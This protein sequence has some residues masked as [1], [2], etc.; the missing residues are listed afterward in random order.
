MVNLSY[1]LRR[2]NI[3]TNITKKQ[4]ESLEAMCL[5]F[6]NSMRE[7]LIDPQ[8]VNDFICTVDA[9]D[10]GEFI[11]FASKQFKMLNT[12]EEVENYRARKENYYD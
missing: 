5:F 3:M 11:A 7:G 10:D 4:L 8:L 1:Q 9:M 6:K 2:E 12:I